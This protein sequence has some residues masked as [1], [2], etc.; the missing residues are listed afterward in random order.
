MWY[1]YIGMY[2]SVNT[3]A[4]TG[5]SKSLKHVNKPRV[6]IGLKKLPFRCFLLC[7]EPLIRR[8]SKLE[9][10]KLPRVKGASMRMI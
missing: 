6:K 7:K 9:K 5:T 2:F 4:F 1:I 8:I 10:R 3:S